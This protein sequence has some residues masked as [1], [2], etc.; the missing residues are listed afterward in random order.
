MKL[1]DE[2]RKI[3]QRIQEALSHPAVFEEAKHSPLAWYERRGYGA[4]Q[5]GR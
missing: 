4:P 2:V 3:S 1:P 5:K